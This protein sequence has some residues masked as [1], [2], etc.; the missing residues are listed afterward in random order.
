MLAESTLTIRAGRIAD[1]P[2]APADLIVVDV[3]FSQKQASCGLLYGDREPV[4]RKFGDLQRDLVMAARMD[5]LPLNLVIEAP[6][7][8]AF[9]SSGNPAGRSIERRG[10]LHRYWHEGLGTAVLLSAMHLLRAVV[11]A[12]PQR[13]IRLFEGFASYKP[14]GKSDHC[15]DVRQLRDVILGRSP[16]GRIVWP[17]ELRLNATDRVQSAFVVAGMDFGVPPV[18]L[19]GG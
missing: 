4:N 11:D 9:A 6:L 10:A 7:S 2:P 15:E 12:R 5:G 14:K 3:G 1:L 13:E 17:E 19:I 16:S 8:V 18:A